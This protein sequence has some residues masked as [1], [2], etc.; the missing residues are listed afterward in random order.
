MSLPKL[1]T[2]TFE[3]LLPSTK[4]KVRYRPFLVREHKILMTM[5]EADNKEVARIVTELIDVCTFKKLNVEKLPHFDIEYIFLNLRSKSIS[6][7]VD[8]I[9]NCDCG[10]KIETQFDIEDLKI[11]TSPDHT[12]KIMLNDDLGVEMSYPKF[13]NVMDVFE[14]DNPESI[15]ELIV[16]C[17]KGIFNKENYWQA[18]EQTPEELKEFVFSLTKQQFDKLEEFF[19]TAPKIVQTVEADCPGCGK[20]NVNRIEGLQNFFV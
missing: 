19:V 10:T 7:K 14:S 5:A 18:S 4:E 2:P 13:S 17:I 8:V 12:T 11:E 6:E 1:D 20:H 15:F 16:E 9:V 3:L